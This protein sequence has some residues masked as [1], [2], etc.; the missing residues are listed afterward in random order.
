MGENKKYIKSVVLAGQSLT[1]ST[2]VSYEHLQNVYEYIDEKI[3]EVTKEKRT[4][5]SLIMGIIL[6]IDICDEY[7]IKRDVLSKEIN[8][9]KIKIDAL[10]KEHNDKLFQEIES[11]KNEY[12]KEIDDIKQYYINENNNNMLVLDSKNNEI[13]NKTELI[14]KL[15]KQLE[16]DK[17]SFG[18]KIEALEEKDANFFHLYELELSK[19]KSEFNKLKQESNS[20]VEKLKELNRQEVERLTA[21]SEAIREEL[22]L[23]DAQIFNLYEIE[24]SQAKQEVNKLRT[25]LKNN[26]NEEIDNLVVQY[27]NELKDAKEQFIKKK[28]EIIDGFEKQIENLGTSLDIGVGESEHKEEYSE[29]VFE[30]EEY[31]TILEE[32]K[33]KEIDELKQQNIRKEKDI[34][35]VIDENQR[36][37]TENE[38]LRNRVSELLSLYAIDEERY[39]ID[40]SL[41]DLFIEDDEDIYIDEVQIES[42][43][44]VK[45][46]ENVYDDG[47]SVDEKEVETLKIQSDIEKGNNKILIR[48]QNEINNSRFNNIK[49]RQRIKGKK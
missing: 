23:R 41:D 31:I 22:E 6:A 21:S 3:S 8:D 28:K 1:L 24:L 42:E 10:T 43:K 34:V 45:V 11:V 48:S 38:F 17:N 39:E 4:S 37:Y 44:E 26:S 16:S 20:Q 25:L 29:A 49:R 35:K 40:S 32:E 2:E 14:S 5:S 27:E 19:V 12:K 7:F 46:L 18:E 13:S 9:L 47:K 30:L 36:I 33:N 15:S